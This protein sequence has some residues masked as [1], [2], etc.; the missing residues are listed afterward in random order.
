MNHIQTVFDQF[1]YFFNQHKL[2]L[3]LLLS[4]LVF[5]FCG[6]TIRRID[7]T[8]A[9]IDLGVLAVIPLSAITVISFMIL[10]GWMIAWQWPVLSEYQHDF[11]ERTFKSLLSWQKV[12]I[13]FSFYLAV[14][15]A[16]ILAT[17][18]FM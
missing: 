3:M 17:A 4:I 1:N 12:L 7:I 10:T 9:P 6:D 14:F 2:G 5:I 16:F 18:A 8:A 15:Y 13:Y 11:L